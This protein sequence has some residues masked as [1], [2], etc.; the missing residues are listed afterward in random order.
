MNAVISLVQYEYARPRLIADR[1]NSVRYIVKAR[2]STRQAADVLKIKGNK[3][4][5][6][7]TVPIESTMNNIRGHGQAGWGTQNQQPHFDIPVK[8]PKQPKPKPQRPQ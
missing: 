5:I 7:R 6:K 3:W 4:W 2:G 1:L 8:L